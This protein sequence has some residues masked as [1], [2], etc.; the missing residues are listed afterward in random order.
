MRRREFLALVGGAAVA[1]PGAAHTQQPDRMRRIGLLMG[2]A[3]NDPE[4]QLWFLAF[5]QKLAELGWREGAN[6]RVEVQWASADP[7][8]MR[9]FA[10][11]LVRLAPD[12]MV[13]N[14]PPVLAVLR[15]ETRSIPIVF[16]Q[17]AD[18]VG[19][20]FVESLARPGGNI[21]GFSNFEF[22]IGEKWLQTLK[23]IAP[24][25]VRIAVVL[26][27]EHVTNAGHLRAVEGAAPSLGVQIS[28]ASVRDAT[29]IERAIAAVAR[30]PNG[31][32]IVLPN[33]VTNSN[34][35][36]I[37]ALAVRHR[38][39]TIYPFRPFVVSGGLM[40]YGPDQAEMFRGAASYVDR[41]LKGA[42][43]ADLPVQMPTKYEL[44]INLKTAKTLGLTVPPTLL[45]RADEL[46]E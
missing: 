4:A 11:E 19:A 37:V 32:L 39:P 34:R 31:G 3:S 25:V 8:R 46:I 10:S 9:V 29:E 42:K 38:L 2:Q 16:M 18:P 13:A 1:W 43:P 17:V 15:Q 12:V 14:T 24:P 36:L 22:A 21:T 20:G 6:I 41:I 27:P 45:A 33:P 5:R 35:E 26:M 28:S 40:S 23:Q 7:K 30:E 44:V